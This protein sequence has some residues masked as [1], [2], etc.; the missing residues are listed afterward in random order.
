MTN[1]EVTIQEG[2][3]YVARIYKPILTEEENKKREE[4]IKAAIVK[5]Y[6]ETRGKK[7]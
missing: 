7:Q 2:K 4:N 3:N 6:K 5:F 1:Y